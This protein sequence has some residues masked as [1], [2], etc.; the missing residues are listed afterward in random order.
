MSP[1]HIS[2]A[3]QI[4]V[5]VGKCF[6]LFSTER[7][8]KNFIS[9]AIIMGIISL[10]TSEDMFRSYSP[11]KNGAFAIV[12]A[13]V[14]IGLFNSIQSICRER[15][16]IKR[17]YRTGLRISSY[18]LAH[19]VYELVLCAVEALIVTVVVCL[20]N[21][22]HL[23][24]SGLLLPMALDLYI[25]LFLVVFSA[26]MIAILV[27]SI[28]HSENTAMTVMPFVLIVQLVMSGAVFPLE[29]M[30]EGISWFTLS[31]WG[32]NAICAIANTNA[33]VEAEYTAIGATG[34]DPEALTLLSAWLLLLAFSAA[35][36][37]LSILFLRRV[38][39]D[40]R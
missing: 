26:D 11:T 7:Q 15:S 2:G 37:A 1:G 20:K 24:D 34:A 18:I 40:K 28:V 32:L 22:N 31:R 25:T 6:R 3:G 23:P 27:S 14:W 29:G 39:K 38:D 4:R 16:I 36:V 13:C 19:V 17:E 9:T 12:C 10:V 8:W 21:F 30:T 33:G 5:Y 35:Y